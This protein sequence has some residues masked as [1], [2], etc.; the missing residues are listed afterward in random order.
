MFT[1]EIV[2]EVNGRAARFIEDAD[3]RDAAQEK[4]IAWLEL[5]GNVHGAIRSITKL[6]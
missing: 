5:E 4:L 1:Y 2:I 3:S 6:W